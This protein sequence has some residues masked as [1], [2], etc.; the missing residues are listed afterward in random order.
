[1]PKKTTRKP[2]TKAAGWK[3]DVPP[4]LP[5]SEEQIR[6]VVSDAVREFLRVGP[7][8][9]GCGIPPHVITAA[10][11]EA[12]LDYII[13]MATSLRNAIPLVDRR[14]AWTNGCRPA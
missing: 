5:L 4:A 8:G 9:P 12:F 6:E 1:M 10:E 14:V 2:A 13:N 11:A 7:W 3:K